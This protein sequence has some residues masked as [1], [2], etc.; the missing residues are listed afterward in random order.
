MTALPD[1]DPY[2]TLG[3][4]KDAT[5]AEIK[6]AH[7]KLVLKCHPDK[8]KDESLRSQAQDQFQ[9][10]QHAYEC[11]SD[12]TSRAKYDTKVKL[13]ELKREMMARNAAYSRPRP[14]E[15]R[16]DGHYYEERVP[17]D[18]RSSSE[19]FFFEDE[20]RFTEPPRP[21]SRKFE[22]YGTR[23]RSRAP[24]E[25]KSSKGFPS[26][27]A[28]A[29]AKEARDSTKAGRADQDR[30]RTKERRRQAYEKRPFDQYSNYSSDSDSG[31]SETYFIQ[32]KRPSRKTKPAE[33]TRRSETRRH[34]D[35]DSYSDE[36][37]YKHDGQNKHDIQYSTAYDY[38]RR[39]KEAINNDSDRRHRSSHS[40][41]R[42]DPADADPS[43]HSS[44]SKRSSRDTRP[45]TSHHSSYEHLETSR[46]YDKVPSMPTAATFP[47]PKGSPSARPS[48]QPSKSS[49]SNVRGQS[50]PTRES[51]RRSEAFHLGGF[52]DHPLRPSKSRGEKS[53]DS[54]YASSSPTA[55][56]P[57][58]GET[59]P[60]PPRH[61]SRVEPVTILEAS[62]QHSPHPQPSRSSKTYSPPRQERR[63]PVRS[64]TYTYPGHASDASPRKLFGEVES[65]E[66]LNHARGAKTR[67]FD[68][69]YIS[70]RYPDEY[71]R[72]APRRQSTLA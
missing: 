16:D 5:L 35:E 70:P 60:K 2:E 41:S 53:A 46:V 55:E 65:K 64:H 56:I 66:E 20:N 58:S 4:A 72:P 8:I 50:R 24:D 3:I 12:E 14:R 11:L 32:V 42:C 13:A 68:I 57:L 36:P 26:S 59:P 62:P 52:P 45:P 31:R 63:V 33:S 10:V 30:Y 71:T 43:R 34:E 27:A 54:G 23:P 49:S 37:V 51:S 69:S 9:K 67:D 29:A 19:A 6:S 7:R 18:A 1:F 15:Y 48:P 38:I 25:K 44:R 39:S 47:G 61:R 17:A 28:R 21:T 40:P 22:E